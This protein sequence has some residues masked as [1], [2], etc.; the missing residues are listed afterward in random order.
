MLAPYNDLEATEEIFA[1][2]P[3]ELACFLVE[4]VA[5]NMGVVPPAPG[6]LAGLRKLCDETGALLVL[7]EVMTGF[8]VGWNS[9]QGLYGVAADLTC[10]GKI[11]G[12]GLPVGAYG[13]SSKFMERIS[14]AGDVYQAGTLSGNP[15]ATSAGLA[16]LEIL[17]EPRAYDILE[18]RGDALAQGLRAAADEAGV[19]LAVNRVGSMLTPFFVRKAGDPVTNF[20]QATASDTAAYARIFPR[21]AGAAGS[22]SPPANSR[23]G[24]SAS[25][26]KT[27]TSPAQSKP[28]ETALRALNS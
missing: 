3:R 4:P 23:H 1:A 19:P 9:A 27:S 20:T 12:G 24:S 28:P 13:G 21:H 15:L 22:I 11:I 25:P 5:G 16:T 14:P 10:L 7:D 26:T 2:H 6:Y 8:R 18:K 17:S